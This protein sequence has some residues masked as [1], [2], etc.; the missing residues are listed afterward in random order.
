VDVPGSPFYSGATGEAY[1][2]E[3]EARGRRDPGPGG[4]PVDFPRVIERAYADG[5]RVFVEHGPR[6]QCTGW[7]R[8]ILAGREHVAVALDRT[9][10]PAPAVRQ[11]GQVVGGTGRGRRAGAASAC[12]TTSSG[13]R[14]PARPTRP[15]RTRP[16]CRPTARDAAARAAMSPPLAPAPPVCRT[17]RPEAAG[18]GRPARRAGPATSSRRV[19]HRGGDRAARGVPGRRLEA[20]RRFLDVRRRL[21]LGL[22]PR[23]TR[24]AAVRPGRAGTASRPGR[25]CSVRVRRARAAAAPHQ[26]PDS[27]DAAG[28]PRDRDRRRP[29][30]DGHRCDA[31]PRPTSARTP[32]TW[33]RPA[34]CRPV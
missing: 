20:Q 21:L 1:R 23:G 16:G 12:S 32:G 5:V 24:G 18:Q 8:Q 17:R 26:P 22:R 10:G 19:G 2:A 28:R 9:D 14:R 3:A 31:G 11:L 7:I 25:A 4:R 33:T 15:T 27:T 6:A 30:L 13:G 29:R 34:R